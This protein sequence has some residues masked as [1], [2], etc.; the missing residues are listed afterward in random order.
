[1]VP[2]A[3]VR[4]RERYCVVVPHTKA[5]VVN[6]KS[7]ELFSRATIRLLSATLTNGVA[8]CMVTSRPVLTTES[9]NTWVI[10]PT[11]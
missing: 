6:A 9:E 2:N 5:G 8:K 4:Y 1:M 10:S 11:G 7:P 3:E